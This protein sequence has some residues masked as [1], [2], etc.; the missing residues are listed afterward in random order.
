MSLVETYK[1]TFTKPCVSMSPYVHWI[2]CNRPDDVVVQYLNGSYSYYHTQM[3]LDPFHNVAAFYVCCEDIGRCWIGE[4]DVDVSRNNVHFQSIKFMLPSILADETSLTH[5][6]SFSDYHSNL[7]E[8]KDAFFK[9][10]LIE[11]VTTM[12]GPQWTFTCA[13][14]DC[15]PTRDTMDM[16]HKLM[17]SRH[18]EYDEKPSYHNGKE[19]S[20]FDAFERLYAYK[21]R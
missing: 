1:H 4:L 5:S 17:E 16:I 2:E 6:S 8:M 18:V 14:Q 10:D 3:T 15:V 7:Y 9:K 21:Y 12:F 20:Y 13:S 11:F 19:V